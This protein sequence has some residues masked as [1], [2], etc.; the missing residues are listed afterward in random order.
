MIELT[1]V[2]LILA[3]VPALLYLANFF[4]YRRAPLPAPGEGPAVS[5]LIPARNEERSIATAV[6]SAL[7]SRGVTVEVVVL[8]DHSEDDTA[9]RVAAIARRDDRV[10]LLTAPSLPPGWCGKQHACHVLA[11][12][13][14]YP[15]LAFLDADVRL[16]PDGLAR[17]AAFQ[18]HSRADLVSGIP[19]QET[20]TILER[21][22]IPLIHFVLLGFLPMAWMRKSIQPAFAAG[23]GQLFL[24]T[25]HGYDK[26]GGHAGIRRT[27][28]D[29]ILLPRAFRAAGLWTDLCDATDLADC[30]MYRG[31]SELW[32]GLAKNATEG[33]AS[34]GTIAPATVLLFGGQVL[35]MALLIAAAWLPVGALILAIIATVLAYSPRFVSAVRFR[36][37]LLGALLH[38]AGICVLLA[39]Q[40]YAFGRSLLRRPATWKG[41]RYQPMVAP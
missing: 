39:I 6:E 12:A 41:R 25:R 40:W 21:M 1:L 23:C 20:G 5:V 4:A 26:S 35:P 16:A 15:L 36:Q 27:L 34:P 19:H 11:G 7:A 38:P 3:S 33:L 10:R 13:A 24:A 30:R 32:H 18:A 8:D 31:A 22:V 28:H 14:R 29:G 2:C 37:S 9:A 17:L